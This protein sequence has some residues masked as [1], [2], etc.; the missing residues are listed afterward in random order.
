MHELSEAGCWNR[1]WDCLRDP[2]T[3]LS[4]TCRGMGRRPPFGTMVTFFALVELF[5]SN[6][7]SLTAFS[8]RR[9]VSYQ[10][11]IDPPALTSTVSRLFSMVR[12]CSSI[13]RDLS[14]CL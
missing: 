4:A 9:Q 2:Q 6:S 5:M 1:T 8:S 3:K 13:D 10:Y 12:K 14:L 11:V 7:A